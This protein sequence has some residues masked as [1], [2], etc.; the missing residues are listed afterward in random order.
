MF[1]FDSSLVLLKLYFDLV[2][3]DSFL[4]LLYRFLSIPKKQVGWVCIE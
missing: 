3:G 4:E 2:F 1:S